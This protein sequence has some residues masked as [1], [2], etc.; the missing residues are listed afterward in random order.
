M[1]RHV[2]ASENVIKWRWMTAQS[3][4]ARGRGDLNTADLGSNPRGLDTS[5][6][7]LFAE[8]KLI[9]I[10]THTRLVFKNSFFEG[11]ELFLT[12]IHFVPSFEF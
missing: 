7:L 1:A 8:R 2:N 10:I 5:L 4:L 11:F 9:K 12:C 3:V 6:S